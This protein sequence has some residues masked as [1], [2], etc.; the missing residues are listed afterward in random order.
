M[1]G[2]RLRCRGCGRYRSPTSIFRFDPDDE[3]ADVVVE[4]CP[5][6]GCGTN[7]ATLAG[8]EA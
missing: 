1:K 7:T 6:D 2:D 5:T 4:P 3:Y 8:G